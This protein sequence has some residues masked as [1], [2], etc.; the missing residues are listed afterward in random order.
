MSE[1][2]LDQ[3]LH[4]CYATQSVSQ[5][6]ESGI[7][8]V[9]HGGEGGVGGG[10]Q[11]PKKTYSMTPTNSCWVLASADECNMHAHRRWIEARAAY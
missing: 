3:L 4:R 7:P 5:I 6:L 2:S 9:A 1:A 10:D 8:P 11:S